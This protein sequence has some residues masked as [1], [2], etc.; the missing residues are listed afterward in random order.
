MRYCGWEGV[1]NEVGGQRSEVGLSDEG[2]IFSKHFHLS[3]FADFRTSGLKKS[4]IKP[5]GKLKHQ[6]PILNIKWPW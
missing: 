1:R 5:I 2:E 3:D 4:I 6:I